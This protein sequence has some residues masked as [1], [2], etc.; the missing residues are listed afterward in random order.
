[1]KR[2]CMGPSI[3]SVNNEDIDQSMNILTDPNLHEYH[4]PLRICG[5]LY[6]FSHFNSSLFLRTNNNI[7]LLKF[8]FNRINKTFHIND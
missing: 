1:M 7:F 6:K 5:S 4:G 3:F 2:L 8:I